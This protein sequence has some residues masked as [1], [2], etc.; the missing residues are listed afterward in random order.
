MLEQ[1]VRRIRNEDVRRD[2]ETLDSWLKRTW[3]AAL[4]E[5][6]REKPRLPRV[7]EARERTA[8]LVALVGQPEQ[9]SEQE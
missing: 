6:E 2:G 7:E 5:Y 3:Q 8:R 9:E 1:I 4:A